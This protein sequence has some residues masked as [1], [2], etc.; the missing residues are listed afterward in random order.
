MRAAA[1]VACAVLPIVACVPSDAVAPNNP[2]APTFEVY[3]PPAGEGGT[4]CTGY[5][6]GP[7]F[8]GNWW[9][10]TSSHCR[11]ALN[12][13]PGIGTQEDAET[14]PYDIEAAFSEPVS[15]LVV[16]PVSIWRCGADPGSVT[17]YGASGESLTLPFVADESQCGDL[18]GDPN[19]THWT[20]T[21][22][23]P[24]ALAIPMGG[25]T[26]VVLRPTSVLIW[27]YPVFQPDGN[28]GFVAIPVTT[29]AATTYLLS[30][31]EMPAQP[32]QLSIVCDR[33]TVTRGES[34]TCEAKATPD[35]PTM[36][37]EEWRFNSLDGFAAVRPASAQGRQWGGVMGTSGT[38][39]LTAHVAGQQKTAT[40]DITV[41]PR[42]WSTKAVTSDIQEVT[43]DHLP[44]LPPSVHELGDV[45][46]TLV[47]RY[48]AV[49][50]VIGEGPNQGLAYLSD[51]P[52]VHQA[53]VSVNLQ[54][55]KRGSQFSDRHP[56]SNAMPGGTCTRDYLAR[57]I[58]PMVR[59]HEGLHLETNSHTWFYKRSI[60]QSGVASTLEGLIGIGSIP[61]GVQGLASGA[62]K[63][64]HDAAGVAASQADAVFPLRLTCTLKF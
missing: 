47:D 50:V 54:A 43:N 34:V 39:T 4:I 6:Q 7:A 15:G 42:D 9:E 18:L 13:S 49:T 21:G 57:A 46:Q 62:V 24:Q 14:G 2:P 35:D 40:A 36:Q 45:A 63:Q 33:T 11:T 29:F 44:I 10:M 1:A 60:E 23:I 51:L 55:L 12:V 48:A 25:V 26:R 19:D 56:E 28:G 3:L 30:F 31:R 32:A 27:T 5:L 61:E 37:F 38:M 53:R 52:F 16:T 58:P 8:V 17:V 64:A 41:T 20:Q 22:T 59:A